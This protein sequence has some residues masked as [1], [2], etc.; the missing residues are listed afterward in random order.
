MKLA[1][2]GPTDVKHFCDLLQRDE[3]EYLDK[4]EKI[5]KYVAQNGFEIVIVPHKDSVSEFFAKIYVDEKGRKVH[6]IYPLKDS[7]F[8]ISGINQDISDETLHPPN[9]REVP[10]F[11]VSNAD[12]M[13]CL[14]LGP[15]SMIEICY[16]KWYPVKKI[17]VLQDFITDRLPAEIESRLN[18]EYIHSRDLPKIAFLKSI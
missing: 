5:A 13:L 8:G 12:A 10:I 15:G 7:E 1:I 3:F 16:A 4:I 14:G 18:I 17:L 9:W 6:G 11:L 2:I